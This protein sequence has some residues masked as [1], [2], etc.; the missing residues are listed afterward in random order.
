MDDSPP[1]KLTLEQHKAMLVH[2]DNSLVTISEREYVGIVLLASAFFMLWQRHN[3]VVEHYMKYDESSPAEG[4]IAL[5]PQAGD[6][7]DAVARHA[8]S[9]PQRVNDNINSA[10]E[11]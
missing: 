1:P 3:A 2:M 6:L 11:L 9:I 4:L 5:Y 7:V 8:E 10:H